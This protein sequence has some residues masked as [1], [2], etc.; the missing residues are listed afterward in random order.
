MGAKP[1]LV[2][3]V[4]PYTTS[5]DQSKLCEGMRHLSEVGRELKTSVRDPKGTLETLLLRLC[6]D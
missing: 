3:K 1:F 5:L 2:E 4:L 6:L